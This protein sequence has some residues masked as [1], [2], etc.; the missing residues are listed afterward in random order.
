VFIVI[1]VLT[2]CF[3]IAVRYGYISNVRYMLL[4]AKA[5]LNWISKDFLA[6][7]WLKL[8]P[9]TLQEQINATR[10]R[11]QFFE[12]EFNFSFVEELPKDLKERFDKEDYYDKSKYDDKDIKQK[13]IIQKEMFKRRKITGSSLEDEFGFIH[14]SSSNI[15]ELEEKPSLSR[16]DTLLVKDKGQIN[17]L[18]QQEE[19]H[20]MQRLCCSYK[21]DTVLREIGLLESAL[22]KFPTFIMLLA[23][24]RIIMQL[25]IQVVQNDFK[26]N[27]YWYEYILTLMYFVIV[28]VL[29]GVNLIF[30]Y[31]GI[32]D[33]K[34]KL[35]YMKIL[36]SIISPEKDE[37][38]LFSTY[39]PTINC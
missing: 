34:R 14:K 8:D 2:R 35:F 21:G 25:I 13:I 29:Y 30:V 27:F 28:V 12:D 3:I 17:N 22:F 16:S 7:G 6:T 15:P 38:F 11:L 19:H 23:I 36:T 24:T 32:V 4:K 9:Q 39:F 26:F 20:Y 18:S 33:F 5:N 37:G 31:A 1:T 10:H